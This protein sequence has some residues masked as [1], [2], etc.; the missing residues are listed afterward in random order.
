MDGWMDQVE[1]W[2]EFHI[3]LFS[4]LVRWVRW[5]AESRPIFG[6]LKCCF[7]SPFLCWQTGKKG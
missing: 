1:W 5:T 2:V 4:G 6:K 3:F 7:F